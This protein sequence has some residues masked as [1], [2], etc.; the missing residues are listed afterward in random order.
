M[1]V[2]LN[3]VKELGFVGCNLFQSNCHSL[4]KKEIP[5]LYTFIVIS[6]LYPKNVEV[7]KLSKEN[8][9]KYKKNK[10]SLVPSGCCAPAAGDRDELSGT[11]MWSGEFKSKKHIKQIVDTIETLIKL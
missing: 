9:S 1:T 7:F 8:Y 6:N 5:E 3:Q 10:V 11:V 2:R 4:Y